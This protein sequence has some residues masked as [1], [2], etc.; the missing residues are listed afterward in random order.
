[1]TARRSGSN[2]IVSPFITDST[3]NAAVT[4]LPL[5]RSDH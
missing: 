2:V 4:S 5:T 3:I 1:M